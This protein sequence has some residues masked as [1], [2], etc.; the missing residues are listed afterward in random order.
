M[1]NCDQVDLNR[2]WVVPAD[3]YPGLG[4][5]ESDPERRRLLRQLE[6]NLSR[7]AWIDGNHQTAKET[8]EEVSRLQHVVVCIAVP[9]RCERAADI[10]EGAFIAENISSNR[11]A[12]KLNGC[13][14]CLPSVPVGRASAAYVLPALTGLP[15]SRRRSPFA[16]GF[17]VE[18]HRDALT[19]Y[20]AARLRRRVSLLLNLFD[21]HELGMNPIEDQYASLGLRERNSELLAVLCDDPEVAR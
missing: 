3:L 17:D 7:E 11:V 16:P 15:R 5:V 9:P 10:L 8:A 14:S 12:T 4:V 1:V 19:E 20:V 6:F 18:R 2:V 13:L 21:W